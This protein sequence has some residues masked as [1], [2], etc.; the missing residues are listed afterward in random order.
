MKIKNKRGL[1]QGENLTGYIFIIPW[2]IGFL[3]F[4]VYPIITAFY[5]GLTKYN[6]VDIPTFI[7]FDNYK[8]LMKDAMFIKSLT[9]SIYFMVIGLPICNVLA[10]VAAFLLQN[11]TRGKSFFRTVF[12]LPVMMPIVATT[13]LWSFMF[14]P[15]YGLF[16]NVLEMVGL[17]GLLWL[18]DVT[19]SKPSLIFMSTWRIGQSIMLYFTAMLSV[20]ASYYEAAVMDGAGMLKQ[21]LNITIPIISPIIFFNLVT[22]MIASFQYFTEPYIMTAGG[23]NG[24]TMTFALYLYRCA[25][26]NLNMGYAASMGCLQLV[27]ILAYT[28]VMFK[29]QNKWVHYQ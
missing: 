16:N 29:L 18:S 24:S 3:I 4:S 23:P 17:D 20:P 12:F 7:A 6:I 10:V 13:L 27:I 28:L 14:N 11:C 22:G 9:N 5:L 21:T 15:Q 8:T 1:S 19:T 2:L 25:F 26:E